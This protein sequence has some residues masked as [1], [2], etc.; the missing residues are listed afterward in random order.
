M[1]KLIASVAALALVS[2]AALAQMRDPAPTT[3]TPSA[4]PIGSTPSKDF[5]VTNYYKQD[6]Y[7]RSDNKIGTIDDV[8]IDKAGGVTALMISVGGFLGMG[9]KTVQTR[10]QNVQMTKKNDKW[11]LTMDATKDSLKAAP[12]YKYDRTA[13]TWVPDTSDSAR[14]TN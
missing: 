6:V 1:N 14:R 13:T 9:E 3:S 10:F 12:G 4:A 5:T 11:Y 2:S 7:D 8:L